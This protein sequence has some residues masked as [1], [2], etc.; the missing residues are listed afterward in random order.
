MPVPQLTPDSTDEEIRAAVLA[1]MEEMMAGGMD[2]AM[3]SKAAQ[4]MVNKMVGR[5][6]A[7]MMSPRVMRK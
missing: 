2:R 3:A 6:V 7:M 4:S 1:I 5:D